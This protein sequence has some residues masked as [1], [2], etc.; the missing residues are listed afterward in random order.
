MMAARLAKY[1]GGGTGQLMQSGGGSTHDMRYRTNLCGAVA[2]PVHR[3]VAGKKQLNG[4]TEKG[5][6]NKTVQTCN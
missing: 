1:R 4:S 2:A 3:R 5:V 6:V